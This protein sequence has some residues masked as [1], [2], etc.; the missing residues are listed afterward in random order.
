MNINHLLEDISIRH[1]CKNV[2]KY[3]ADVE[4]AVGIK[5]EPADDDSLEFTWSKNFEWY[6]DAMD[7]KDNILEYIGHQKMFSVK[8]REISGH[9]KL[10]FT[11]KFH[12][13]NEV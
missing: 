3:I 10:S 1:A 4:K 13:E 8:D 11:F 6:S 5:L 9:Y 12:P 7:A 2:S